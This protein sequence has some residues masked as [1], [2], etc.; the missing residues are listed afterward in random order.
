MGRSRMRALC[1]FN[2]HLFI[3]HFQ[4]SMQE[5]TVPPRNQAN[6]SMSEMQA[7]RIVPEDTY[8]FENDT[9][10]LPCTS[11]RK[12]GALF[13]KK[14]RVRLSIDEKLTKHSP[15]T[16]DIVGNHSLGVFDLLISQ[17]RLTDTGSYFCI[18]AAV[19]DHMYVISEPARL[20]VCK[21]SMCY[22]S[23]GLYHCTCTN[24]KF[25][26]GDKEL[27][28]VT[29]SPVNITNEAFELLLTDGFSDCSCFRCAMAMEIDIGLDVFPC[30]DNDTI[31]GNRCPPP[32]NGSAWHQ[33]FEQISA[34]TY[35]TF[36]DAI[37]PHF[38]EVLKQGSATLFD[39]SKTNN[40]T[41]CQ[42][43]CVDTFRQIDDFGL[44]LIQRIHD[45]FIDNKTVTIQS[46]SADRGMYIELTSFVNEDVEEYIFPSD[47][48]SLDG[49]NITLPRQVLPSGNGY[50][51]N[52]KYSNLTSPWRE[53]I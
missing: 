24:V 36:D 51:I 34:W 6:V 42:S 7:L 17:A 16:F 20:F 23:V 53:Q 12:A 46:A 28:S 45:H 27:S 49:D 40:F 35:R 29:M 33:R 37:V 19:T 8:A 3:L 47:V 41:F 10:V 14:D 39:Q 11:V 18:L 21:A 2:F 1:V 32:L 43:D 30:F 25:R 15:D 5:S 31:D 38:Q 22:T 4:G 44:H 52:V 9:V 50:L 13:W 48:S 26:R